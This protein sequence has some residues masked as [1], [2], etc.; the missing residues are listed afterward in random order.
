MA[1]GIFGGNKSP[2]KSAEDI[3]AEELEKAE[4]DALNKEPKKE[5]DDDSTPKVEIKGKNVVVENE[6]GQ[7]VRTYS[8]EQHGKGFLD[9]AKMFI[10]KP[11]NAERGF[12]L[13]K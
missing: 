5:T 6:K 10:S 11:K 3:A 13:R 7:Y 4:K 9:L 12:R 1:K 2:E 8:E